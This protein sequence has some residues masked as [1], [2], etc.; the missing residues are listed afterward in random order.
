MVFVIYP[1]HDPGINDTLS[2]RSPPPLYSVAKEVNCNFV[3]GCQ[4]L[5]PTLW[6]VW[7]WTKNGSLLFSDI[8]KAFWWLRKGKFATVKEKYGK[9]STFD[10]TPQMIS[11]QDVKQGAPDRKLSNPALHNHRLQL[12]ATNASFLVYICFF[13]VHHSSW[14]DKSLT[15]LW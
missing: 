7:L 4:E 12:C 5:A 15:T 8:K 10:G 1:H 2:P 11:F 13:K 6:L 3:I 14:H 9:C